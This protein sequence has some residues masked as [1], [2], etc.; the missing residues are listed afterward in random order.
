MYWN[1]DRFVDDF[2]IKYWS[3]MLFW[4]CYTLCFWFQQRLG[5]SSDCSFERLNLLFFLYSFYARGKVLV[6]NKPFCIAWEI[7]DYTFSASIIWCKALLTIERYVLV[8]HPH[9]L[10]SKRQQFLFHSLP[11]ILIGLYL[12]HFYVFMNIFCPW[13]VVLTFEKY[14][15]GTHCLDHAS[16]V[17]TFNWLFNILFPVFIVIFG[18]IILLARVIWKR[19]E[20]Q[21]NLRNWSKNWKMIVQLLGLALIYAIVWL[22][23]SA[24]S[25]LS[26]A[27]ILNE[28]GESTADH[29]YYLTLHCELLVTI[30][31][32]LFWPDIMQ[33][34][35]P[36]LRSNSIV[37]VTMGAYSTN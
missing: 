5:L 30:M 7:G 21:R 17:S 8:F 16:G 9:Y 2:K 26:M 25:L 13:D 15:C 1:F 22:P 12:V 34:L 10:R 28:A 23:M 18:S 11:L 35:R 14:M 20:M 24:I 29:F 36:N 37:S 4:W 32:L 3:F 19:R 27:G 31:A 6:C 33:K